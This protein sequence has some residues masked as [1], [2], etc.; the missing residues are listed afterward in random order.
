MRNLVAAVSVGIVDGEACLDLDYA[1]DVR[2][3][4]D[5]NFAA[6]ED[7]RIV[8]VQGTAEGQPFGRDE[9]DLMLSLAQAG[10]HQLIT[11]QRRAVEAAP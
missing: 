8:E 9:L 5:M 4:V 3:E 10:V 6:L 2:A 1:E 11:L 7:G